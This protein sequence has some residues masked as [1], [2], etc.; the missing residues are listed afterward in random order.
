[1]WSRIIVSGWRSRLREQTVDGGAQ[2]AKAGLDDAPNQAVV[3]GGVPVDQHIAEGDD[4]RQ[5]GN[6][7]G[8]KCIDPRQPVEGFADDLELALDCGTEVFVR[9]VVGKALAGREA[10]DARGRLL[11]VPQQLA[12][13][14]VHRRS[15]FHWRCGRGNRGWRDCCR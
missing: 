8:D 9:F 10:C 11:R 12:S 15:G 1:M 7:I 14:S 4:A 2:P 13:I 6:L 3:H 5:L